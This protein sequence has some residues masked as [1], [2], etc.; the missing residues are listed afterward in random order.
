MADHDHSVTLE[1]GCFEKIIEKVS[2]EDLVNIARDLGPRTVKG[3]FAFFDITPTLD[4]L[5]SKYFRPAGAF[6]DG[7]DFNVSG[8]GPNLKLVLTHSYG[9]KWSYFL[10]EYCDCLIESVLAV[11]PKTRVEEDLVIIE[12]GFRT[13]AASHP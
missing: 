4:S 13:P 8:E 1:R 2:S 3:D 6:S 12:F 5:I 10:A 9:H 11:R 7:F